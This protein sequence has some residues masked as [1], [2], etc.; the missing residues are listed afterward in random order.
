MDGGVRSSSLLGRCQ[1][2]RNSGGRTNNVRVARSKLRIQHGLRGRHHATAAASKAPLAVAACQA[3]LYELQS[4]EK[5]ALRRRHGEAMEVDSDASSS[6]S[7]SAKN[8]KPK[9]HEVVAAGS[10]LWGLVQQHGGPCGIL[11][12]V[13]AELLRLLLQE[14]QEQEVTS[15]AVRQA[16]AMAVGGILAR[17]ALAPS[18]ASAPADAAADATTTNK[19]VTLVHPT[20]PVA[21]TKEE[22]TMAVDGA[23]EYCTGLAWDALAPWSSRSDFTDA[24]TVSSSVLK[25][26]FISPPSQP[27]NKDPVDALVTEVCRFLL[28]P[29]KAGPSMLTCPLEYFHLSGGVMLLTM[30][31][32]A[33]R[34]VPQIQSGAYFR[35]I[36]LCSLRHLTLSFGSLQKWT[37]HPWH[38][39]RP[40]LD[41]PLKN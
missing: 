41:I 13:Q 3:A 15:D 17:A 38:V 8:K 33:S 10:S 26:H 4:F 12:S 32:V 23:G 9:R 34:G 14:Q 1:C 39:S 18:A 40:N 20:A 36:G 21:P 35:H 27:C 2:D 28:H 7:S 37:I 30:S 22:G 31:L 19:T 11:A 16:L 6:S 29:G 25:F 5:L 24:T